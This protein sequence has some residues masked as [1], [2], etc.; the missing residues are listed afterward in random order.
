MD[1]SVYRPKAMLFLDL[2]GTLNKYVLKLGYS[3]HEKKV[4]YINYQLLLPW[5]FPTVIQIGPNGE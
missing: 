1:Y 2:K 4:L 3:V 5:N